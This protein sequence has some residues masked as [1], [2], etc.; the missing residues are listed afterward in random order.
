MAAAFSAL[1]ERA[2]GLALFTYPEE[3]RNEA[4]AS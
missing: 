2:E 4:V 1:R 3:K